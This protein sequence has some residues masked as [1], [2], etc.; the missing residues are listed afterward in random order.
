[1]SVTWMKEYVKAVLKEAVGIEEHSD[2]IY[3]YDTSEH[4]G[5]TGGRM[6]YF[7]NC[8]GAC[9]IFD[10]TGFHKEALQLMERAAKACKYSMMHYITSEMQS[11]IIDAL[12]ELGWT[13]GQTVLNNNSGRHI[14]SWTKE[15][16]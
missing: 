1:M 11:Y 15:V 16:V 10:V 8:C 5:N 6:T 4:L 3:V 2:H 9:I 12:R 7:I 13:E 14:T